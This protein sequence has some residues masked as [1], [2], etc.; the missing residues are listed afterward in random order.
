MKITEAM[1][2][3]KVIEKRMVGNMQDITRYYSAISSEKLLFQ[4]EDKQ[5][6]EVRQL[7]QANSDLLKE[8]L[9][10]K[11]KIEKTNLTITVELGGANYVLSDL[12]IIK[13]KLAKLMMDTYAAINDSMGEQRLRGASGIRDTEG[14]APYIVRL[15]D[16]KAK[17]DGRRHWMELYDSIASRLEV[18]NATT[19]IVE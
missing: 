5:K 1:K 6:A 15:Y 7:I 18:I 9:V 2:R 4:T 3:L 17:N 16:E 10:L 11:K 13:R 14:K 19:D 8:Y 12:L